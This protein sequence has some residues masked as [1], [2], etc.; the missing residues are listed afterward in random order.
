ML[1]KNK[2]IIKI[3]R[4]FLVLSL[5][6]CWISISST[7]DDLLIFEKNTNLNFKELINFL[8][9]ISIY[10]CFLFKIT[11]FIFFREKIHFKKYF[12][13]YFLTLYFISQIFGLLFT[14]NS[15]NN[16]SFIVSALSTIFTIILLDAFLLNN[17]KKKLLFIVFIIL[18]GV[19]FVTFIPTFLAFL[20]GETPMY[21]HFFKYGFLDKNLPRSSGLGRIVL[22]ILILI[23]FFEFNF[24]KK[25][26]SIN[27]IKIIFL[28]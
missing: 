1:I 6:A 22:I 19:F 20:K 25:I 4:L 7:F 27:F 18:L 16:I 28:V 17:E 13:F 14:D 3:I 24:L 15:I 21:G 8:R 2:K 23:E 11:V 12:I 26:L 5:I 10:I 9:H